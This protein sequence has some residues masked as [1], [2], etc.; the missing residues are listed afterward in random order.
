MKPDASKLFFNWLL[1]PPSQPE[2]HLN[3]DKKKDYCFENIPFVN[4]LFFFLDLKIF[5]K[6]FEELKDII[7][8]FASIVHSFILFCL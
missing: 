5:S 2:F 6:S 3:L 7:M 8:I 1:F 4:Y